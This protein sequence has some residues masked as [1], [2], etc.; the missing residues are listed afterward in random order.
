MNSAYW[1]SPGPGDPWPLASG[2]QNRCWKSTG[3]VTTPVATTTA[4]LKALIKADGPLMGGLMSWNDMYQSVAD[5]KANYHG[6]V[7]GGDHAVVIEG[8]QDDQYCPNGG[9]FI[10][11]NSW[12]TGNGDN[13]YWLV[14][15]GVF[16]NHAESFV[17]PGPVYYTGPMYHST[18]GGVQ[19]PDLGGTTHH[20]HGLHGNGGHEH[21]EG[22]DQR[23]VG[24]HV[25]HR[26]QLA[27]QCDRRNVHLGQPGIA[28]CL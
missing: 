21:L 1:D 23:H 15:Y 16:E 11:K 14:P 2:W 9:Y 19:D 13:G 24:H 27:E 6:T 18:A 4:A 7:N 5:L 8:Y 26:R 10:I 22:S 12:G 28:G 17:L 3:T 20:R 25:R